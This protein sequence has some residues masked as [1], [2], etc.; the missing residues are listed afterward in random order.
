MIRQWKDVKK[1]VKVAHHLIQ[2]CKER[3]LS[4]RVVLNAILYG[5]KLYFIDKNALVTK[6]IDGN[7]GVVQVKDRLITAIYL[8][9]IKAKNKFLK[10]NETFMFE[11]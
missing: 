10:N 7:I 3:A 8:G 9:S 6:H 4:P 1:H 2:R 11:E 5:K